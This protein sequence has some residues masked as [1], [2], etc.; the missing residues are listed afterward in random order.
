[1]YNYYINGA[2]MSSEQTYQQGD[3]ILL[4]LTEEQ[5]AVLRA[6]WEEGRDIFNG[7]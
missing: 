3:C 4:R 1:M 5:A 6:E 7:H 2:A